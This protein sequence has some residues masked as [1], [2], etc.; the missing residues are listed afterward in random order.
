MNATLAGCVTLSPGSRSY[1]ARLSCPDPVNLPALVACGPLGLLG[2][3]LLA[4][5][6]SV[7]L[8][9]EATLAP[10]DLA[11]AVREAGT[12]VISGFQSPPERDCL[13]YLLRGDQPVVVCP[14]RSIERM[15]VPGPWERAIAA[16][17]MLLLSECSPGCRRASAST[18]HAR[19]RLVADLADRILV[20][21]ATPGGRLSRL[22]HEAL[23]AGKRVMCLDL[24][25]NEEL[26]VL[27]AL[28][29]DPTRLS[30]PEILTPSPSAPSSH[31]SD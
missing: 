16:G 24:R 28:P 13:D 9:G 17:R 10:Y 21:H 31:A 7:E 27:G 3:P 11:R 23:R 14:A 15:R 22:A 26:L 8:P 25:A 4:V 29:V 1:P 20:I 19:N 5:F 18:A 6:S 2:L 12:P 30:S